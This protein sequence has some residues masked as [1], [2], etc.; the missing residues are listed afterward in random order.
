VGQNQYYWSLLWKNSQQVDNEIYDRYGER[1]YTAYDDPVALLRA[2]N[3]VKIPWILDRIREIGAP[4]HKVLDVGCGGGFLSNDF[5]KRHFNVTGVDLSAKSIDTALAHDVTHT[6]KYIVADAH[7]LPFEDESFDIVTSMDVLEQVKDPKEIIK[8]CSR[9][10]KKKGLF[11]FHTFN[12]NRFSELVVI[13]LVEKFIKNTPK[14]MH[15]ID[16]FIKPEEARSYCQEAGMEVESMTGIRPVFSSVGVK[17][18]M[19]G[20]VSP[21]MRFKLTHNMLISYMGVARKL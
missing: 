19:T 7:T 11:F 9:V 20:V 3:V 10:L 21:R 13:D 1:W 2:E 8:E 12:R 16:L 14:N 18:M 15:V 5:A 6:A 4:G 17:T